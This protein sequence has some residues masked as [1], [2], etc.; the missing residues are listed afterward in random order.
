MHKMIKNKFVSTCL[1]TLF[2]FS[3][4]HAQVSDTK[5]LQLLAEESYQELLEKFN[6]N[7]SKDDTKTN[8]LYAKAFLLKAKEENN[9]SKIADGFSM[10][11]GMSNNVEALAY[12]DSIISITK[13]N[14]DYNYP[15]KAHLLK[16]N[17]LGAQSNFQESMN[18]LAEANKYANENK[19][20]DQQNEIKYYIALLKNNLGQHEESLEIFKS[21][22][23]YYEDKYQQDRTYKNKY[24]VSLYAYGN[25]FNILEVYDSAQ[26][27]NNKAI[28]LSLKSKDSSLYDKLLLSSAIVHYNK[29]EYQSGLDSIK[30]LQK[31]N[32]NK[33]DQLGIGTKIRI[34]L[35]LG[36]IYA[37]QKK[38]EQSLVYFKKVDSAAFSENYY[39]PAI[40]DNYE[41]LIKY[42]KDKKNIE[43][44]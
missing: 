37:E 15:A 31:L 20:I 5:K 22:V 21:V 39:F 42:Y 10:L 27:I 40:R 33:Q 30:K 25:A 16:A 11:A 44:Q 26:K 38:L 34:N 43:Q 8:Q 6:S 2:G 3:I 17:I 32:T 9:F 13:D 19:N 28:R 29:K 12:A 18:E 41:S 1:L 23:E 14:S 24:M 4:A 36:K 35:F 7:D